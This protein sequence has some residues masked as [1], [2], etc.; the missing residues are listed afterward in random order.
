MNEDSEAT[1]EEAGSYE[2]PDMERNYD[3]TCRLTYLDIPGKRNSIDSES[4]AEMN[5][6][7]DTPSETSRTSQDPLPN[8]EYVSA[9]PSRR[10]KRR[11]PKFLLGSKHFISHIFFIWIF[12]LVNTC[13]RVSDIRNI[14]FQLKPS[15]TAKVTGDILEQIWKQEV[16]NKSR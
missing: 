5:E 12:Q 16:E 14:H 8:S 10:K 7:G 6:A 2:P 11:K 4:S 13:R 15:E 9:L 3:S 1:G